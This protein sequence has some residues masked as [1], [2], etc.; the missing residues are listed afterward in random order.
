VRFIS[1]SWEDVYSDSVK[2]ARIIRSS[3]HSR[4]ECIL[5]VSRGGL[6]LARILSDLLDIQN[7]MVIRCEYYSD[8]GERMSK[9]T[10]TQGVGADAITNKSVLIVDDVADSGESLLAV[11]EDISSKGPR[12]LKIAT[13]FVKP[14][15]KIVPDYF[16]RKTSAWIIF[17][18][19]Y[20]E[21]IKSLSSSSN[22]KGI[23]AKTRIPARYI[24]SLY[25]MDPTL[26][27]AWQSKKGAIV[28][29]RKSNQKEN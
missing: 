21:S 25:R 26:A 23:L 11:K 13:I 2:L 16:R 29:K 22:S 7:L 8:I 4:Y 3:E 28:P 20:Y 15:T 10:I 14:W 12:S 18:W 9:P 17:P 27:K 24:K 6:V 19:E 1:P 5:G